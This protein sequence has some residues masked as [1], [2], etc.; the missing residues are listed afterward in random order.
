MFDQTLFAT[1]KQPGTGPIYDQ[2]LGERIHLLLTADETGGS[3]SLLIDEVPPQAGPPLH[4]HR[5]EDELLYVLEGEFLVQRQGEIIRLTAG[6]AIFLPR[7]IPH[8]FINP[9]AK[10]ARVLAA[11]TPGGLEQFFAEVEPLATV[12]EPDMAAVLRVASRYGIEAVGPPLAG[13]PIGDGPFTSPDQETVLEFPTGETVQFLA[14]GEQTGGQIALFQG[15]FPPGSGTSFHRH[16]REDEVIYI[17]DGTFTGRLGDSGAEVEIG[18]GAAV[19]LPRGDF[20]QTVNQSSRPVR[21]LA[22]AFPAGLERYFMAVHE[23]IAQGP[24]DPAAIAAIGR[25]FG[26]ESRPSPVDKQQHQK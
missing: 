5:H 18:T 24:P 14:T 6:Q 8:T 12:E 4:I 2:L 19:F 17:L 10:T 22:F 7:G 9:G 21:G 11:L 20:H 3:I 15:Y 26:V 13:G 23:L 16:L 1:L 25:E